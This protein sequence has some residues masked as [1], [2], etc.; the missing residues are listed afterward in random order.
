MEIESNGVPG[1]HVTGEQLDRLRDGSL[2]PA[3]VAA[4]G[5]HAAACEA[6]GRAVGEAL[7]LHRMTRDLRMQI[8]SGDETEHLSDDELMAVADG[9]LRDDPHLQECEVCRAELEALVRF[10]STIQPRV[11]RT[12]L[13]YAVAA[14]IAAIALTIPLLDRTPRT[15]ATPPPPST[16]AGPVTPEPP[17]VAGATAYD[18]PELD[19][20]VADV[21]AHRV[22]PM[23]AV[24]AE[25]RP[26]KTRLRG[27]A[28][29]DDLRL[30]PDDA[31]VAGTRPRFQ[32]AARAGAMYRVILRNGGEVV[33][34]DALTDAQ[35][36]PPHDLQRGGEYLW[37]VEMTAGGERSIYPKAPNPPARFRVLAQS[38]VTEIAEVRKRYPDDALVQAV[39]LARYGLRDETLAALDRLEQSDAALA[40]DLRQS[41]RSWRRQAPS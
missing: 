2:A 6:C 36:T 10:K 3:A 40:R 28:E 37:Q 5:R 29:E 16:I 33:E 4:V 18:R 21:K 17:P 25:L 13:P 22:L 35:W 34:S 26:Q 31:V 14:S 12:W 38:A 20:W 41:L 1:P 24:I 15:P 39:I 32:W 9:T 19:A 30:S 8:E 11:H 23:P 27:T 7:P